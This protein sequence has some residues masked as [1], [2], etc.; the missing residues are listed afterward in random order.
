VTR[1]VN[2][3]SAAPFD[4]LN[5][6]GAAREDA[7][8]MDAVFKRL[9]VE[10]CTFCGDPDAKRVSTDPNANGD[11]FLMYV[12]DAHADAVTIQA[13]FVAQQRGWWP[14]EGPGYSVG[15]RSPPKPPGKVY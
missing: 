14:P 10:T 6:M 7:A 2:R 15:F 5:V 4:L 1:E 11:A 3:T 8:P 12:C 9:G 13:V